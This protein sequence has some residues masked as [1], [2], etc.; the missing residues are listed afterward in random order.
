MTSEAW[1]SPWPSPRGNLKNLR[2]RLIFG[3]KH[4]DDHSNAIVH[5]SCG[6]EFPDASVDDGETGFPS[7]EG[8][9]FLV[10]S[11][12]RQAS[13]VGVELVMQDFWEMVENLKVKFPPRQFFEE[14][15]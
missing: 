6:K 15:W 2:F 10:G 8:F 1:A 9:K 3:E 11:K 4:C 14:L 7:F 13:P 5:K 12:P